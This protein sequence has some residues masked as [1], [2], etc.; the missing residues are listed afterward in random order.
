MRKV[1]RLFNILASIAAGTLAIQ[2]IAV[3]AQSLP[4]ANVSGAVGQD[5]ADEADVGDDGV[6]DAEGLKIRKANSFVTPY[7]EA[8]QVVSAELSPGNDLVTWTSLAAGVDAGISGRKAEGA[9]SV[10]YERRFEWGGNGADGDALSG[11]ARARATVVPRLLSIE[12][13]AMAARLGVE[14]NGSTNNG[15]RFS[16]SATQ[17]Y[18]LYGGPTLQTRISGVDIEGHYRVGYTRADS[19]DVLAVA[20]GQIPV[21]VFDESITHNAAFRIGTKPRDVMPV[22]LGVGGGWNYEDISNLDQRIDDKHIRADVTV[23]VA[24]HVALVGGIGYEKVRIS[25]RDALR[26]PDTNLP[27][28]GT[29]G[30]FVTD[31]SQ[32]RQ[33]AYEAD[34]LIWDAGVIWKPSKRTALEAYVGKR[35]GST[36]YHGTFAYAPNRITSINLA[37]YDNITSFG[38]QVNNALAALPAQFEAVR[39]PL[40]GDLGG[41]VVN[42]GNQTAAQ[43]STQNNCLLSALGSIRSAAYRGRGVTGS[44]TFNRGTLRYGAGMGYDRRKFIA[45]PGT[46]LAVANGVVDKSIWASAFLN[47]RIDDKSSYGANLWANWFQSGDAFS[48]DGTALGT[49]V[50]YYRSISDRLTGTAAVGVQGVSRERL[51]DLWSAQAMVGIRYSF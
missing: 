14:N 13:G 38:G 37:V 2:P 42:T 23:P 36:S 8:Q 3:S 27:V 48:G 32:P 40:N 51:S 21:D 1:S 34:G 28:I 16:D 9:A 11:L 26:D 15:R 46:I 25:S 49:S 47:G 10:R 5:S 19:P 35:Y 20:P 7:I 43:N 41:C 24:D 29:D 31:K 45:A 6:V 22:G 39:D 44:L 12:G 17:I 33:I 18:S 30:R 4:Y 50:A